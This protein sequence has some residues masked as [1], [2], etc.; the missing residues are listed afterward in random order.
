MKPIRLLLSVTGLLIASCQTTSTTTPDRF[1]V[2]DSDRDGQ[3]SRDEAIHY[4]VSS[5]HDALDLN[6]DGVVT[7]NEAAPD[8]D[9]YL[10]GRFTKRDANGDGKVTL[11][12]AL[13]FA[14]KEGTYDGFLKEADTD[15]SG[16]VSR[17]EAVA[18]TSSKEGP[19]R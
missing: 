12:E 17:A 6:H 15:K 8:K 2:A 10:V 16:A 11:E 14:R 19:V 4:A 13:A 18:Y 3:L 1:A 5:M 9:T 7:L